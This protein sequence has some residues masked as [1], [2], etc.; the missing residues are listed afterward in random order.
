[1]SP[2]RYFLR[3]AYDGSHFHGWQRQPNATTVQQTLEEAMSMMLRL[4]VLLT[5]AGR[6]DTGVH[7]DEFFA[8]FD[9]DHVLTKMSCER[10]V[11]RLNRFL[12]GEIA[13]FEISPVA[14][15][16]H[17]RFS[18]ISRTYRY[19]ISRVPNPFR[20]DFTHPVYS[21]I[22]DEAM[23]TGAA[24]LMGYHDFTSFSKVDTDSATNICKISHARWEMEG[25]EL[26]FTITA[27][28]F[29]RN[30]VRAIVGTLLQLGTGKISLGE[31]RQIIESKNRSN[32]GDS[33]PARGLTL[34]RIVYPAEVFL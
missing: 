6:T 3:L 30:M 22:D 19:C 7:A 28:R 17:A 13:L 8:H 24:I 32:A 12:G 1:M 20:R 23:N 27:D 2:N 16:A 33:A 14:F 15:N 9:S 31:L 26:V 25:E 4:P 10:L 21:Q 11:F 34:H 29:L 5:G 18:A